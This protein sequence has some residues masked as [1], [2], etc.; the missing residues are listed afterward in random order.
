MTL[1]C[2]KLNIYENKFL[3]RCDFKLSFVLIFTTQ[4]GKT[5]FLSNVLA[6]RGP[7]YRKKPQDTRLET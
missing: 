2:N 6:F 7:V 3:V 5:K 1:W 4:L